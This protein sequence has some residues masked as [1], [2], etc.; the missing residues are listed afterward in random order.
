MEG[1]AHTWNTVRSPVAI[2][3]LL[4]TFIADKTVVDEP[5]TRSV[6]NAVIATE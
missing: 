3:S 6:V 1:V 2:R 4:T 5:T